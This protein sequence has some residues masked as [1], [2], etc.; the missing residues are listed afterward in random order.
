M[1]SDLHRNLP[2]SGLMIPDLKASGLRISLY[3]VA[4]AAIGVPTSMATW[5]AL[6]LIGY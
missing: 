2:M 1:R 3:T 6:A 4:I 5:V